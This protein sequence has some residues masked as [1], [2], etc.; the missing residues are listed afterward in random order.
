LH[1][2]PTYTHLTAA[3]SFLEAHALEITIIMC[4]WTDPSCLPKVFMGLKVKV[5]LNNG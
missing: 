2:K 3:A 4:L 5:M 1:I